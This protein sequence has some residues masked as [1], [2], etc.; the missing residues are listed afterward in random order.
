MAKP[1]HID[2]AD[3]LKSYINIHRDVD[4]HRV[5]DNKNTKEKE[6]EEV[7]ENK[8]TNVENYIEQHCVY[9]ETQEVN[10]EPKQVGYSNMSMHNEDDYTE[11]NVVVEYSGNKHHKET[12]KMLKE[13][14]KSTKELS[15]NMDGSSDST[16]LS[17][18]WTFKGSKH[19]E[20][21]IK[22]MKSIKVMLAS[23]HSR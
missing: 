2:D 11:L 5:I 20:T 15:F 16:T 6:M 8:K 19:L 14:R 13:L 7:Q 23:V 18:S 10:K 4:D 3:C 22:S 21:C 17:V 9:E 1:T 12:M